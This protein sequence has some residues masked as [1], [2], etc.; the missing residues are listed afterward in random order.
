MIE[1]SL[2]GTDQVLQK[3]NLRRWYGVVMF[4]GR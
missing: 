4:A 2:K 3:Q 1:K